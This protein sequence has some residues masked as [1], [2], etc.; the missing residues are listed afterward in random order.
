[1]QTRENDLELRVGF[2]LYTSKAQ[3]SK[4]TTELYFDM[5]KPHTVC[6]RI[7]QSSIAKDDFELTPVLNMNGIAAGL[8]T[9]KVEMYESWGSGE[10]L[11]SDS[12]EVTVEYVPVRREARLIKTSIV[13][14]IAGADLVVI[15]EEEKNI[16]HETEE[17]V[18][19]ELIS[20]RDDW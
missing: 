15:S 8:H 13:M 9:I 20:K 5:Q 6:V 14:S 19:R 2:R 7:P 10:K 4:V 12:K 16:Y 18:R 1:M 3:S 17:S 11:A